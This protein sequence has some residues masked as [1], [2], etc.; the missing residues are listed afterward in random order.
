MG[1]GGRRGLVILCRLALDRWGYE[2][3]RQA[4][5]GFT[6]NIEVREFSA[7]CYCWLHY[8]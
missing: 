2:L 6:G 7:F 1:V 5:T 4:S 8:N 3:R